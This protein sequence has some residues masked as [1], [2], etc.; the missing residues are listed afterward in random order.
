MEELRY[1]D[2]KLPN[3][4]NSNIAVRISGEQNLNNNTK[5]I[6]QKKVF[7]LT[8]TDVVFAI[9]LA[10]LNCLFVT[11]TGWGK[12]QLVTDIAYHH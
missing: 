8:L 1:E 7:E 2:L 10:G 11:N 9:E 6:S 5:K 12:T 3:Y 4:V